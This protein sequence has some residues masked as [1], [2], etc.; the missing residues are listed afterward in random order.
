MLKIY[1]SHGLNMRRGRV[2]Y[3]LSRILVKCNGFW[4]ICRH[5]VLIQPF[6]SPRAVVKIL[7]AY[8]Q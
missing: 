5:T 1:A 6:F 8:D 2:F 7:T 3:I 4:I